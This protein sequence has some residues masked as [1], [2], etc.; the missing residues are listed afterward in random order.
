MYI[1]SLK[2]TD[3]GFQV[4]GTEES[5]Q[6]GVRSRWKFGQ[7]LDYEVVAMTSRHGH[8]FYVAGA[9]ANS[10]VLER[11]DLS[12]GDGAFFTE[13]KVS[14]SPPGVEVD[15]IPTVLRLNRPYLEPGSRLAPAFSRVALSL[16]TDCVWILALGA[17]PEGR[18]VLIAGK[19]SQG[20]GA[21][22]RRDSSSGAFTRILEEGSYPFVAD[23]TG[24]RFQDST[25][26]GRLLRVFT[27]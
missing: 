3:A 11:F 4:N 26:E 8:E 20:L 13:K 21:I 23:V 15:P 16:P 22:W 9:A 14:G 2:R 7:E 1:T 24:F 25:L 12:V 19:D 6:T 5:P 17:D 27:S 10:L 18:F